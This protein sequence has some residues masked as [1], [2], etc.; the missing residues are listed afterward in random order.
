MPIS[1]PLS[2]DQFLAYF[3]AVYEASPWAAEAVYPRWSRGE[4]KAPGA[5]ATAMRE[6]VDA[7]PRSE[8]LL[9][10]CAHPELA[11]R[12]RMADASVREQQGAGLD[13]CSEEE[14]A[15]FQGLNTAYTARFGHPF[16][17]AVRGLGRAEIL[18]AFRARLAHDP[19]TEFKTCMSEI[20]RIAGFRLADILGE[21]A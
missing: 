8:R 19:E 14:F 21:A 13:Q 9:L 12:T 15:A 11:S 7:A 18:A 5:L 17:I 20:H 10:I 3:G 6:A 16:I 2:L 4:L 1:P